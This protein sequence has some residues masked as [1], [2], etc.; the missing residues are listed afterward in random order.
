M[1][2]TEREVKQ[3]RERLIDY[4]GSAIPFF[5]IAS[6]DVIRVEQMSDEKVIEEAKR[7]RLI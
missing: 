6:A 1:E 5:S 7:L 3:I 4:Y 2:Y